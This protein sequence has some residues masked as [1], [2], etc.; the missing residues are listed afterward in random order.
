MSSPI[1]A[2]VSDHDQDA[3]ESSDLL[4]VPAAE[5]TAGITVCH[6]D[7]PH[8]VYGGRGRGSANVRT[9]PPEERG[10]LGNPFK[11][12]DSD[13]RAEVIARYVPTFYGRLASDPDFRAAVLDLP[14][15]RV[16]CW[17]RHAEEDAPA[18]HLDVVDQF[19]RG[20]RLFVREFL[21]DELGVRLERTGDGTAEVITGP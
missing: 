2:P 15:K 6:R 3:Q 16:A 19:L 13:D 17:C 10:W 5:I 20:G 18:C 4:G 12:G 9:T 1:P 14:G 21:R 11:L 8:D 7:D